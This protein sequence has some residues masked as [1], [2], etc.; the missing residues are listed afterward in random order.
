[1]RTK[2]LIAC[3]VFVTISL[4]A[5]GDTITNYVINFTTTSGSPTPAS[6]SFTYD[7]SNPLFS[8]FLVTWNG[9][10]FDLTALANAPGLGLIGCTGES[11]TPAYGF[12][13]LSQSLAGCAPTYTWAAM[14]L[15]FMPAANFSFN[16]LVG[17][18][19]ISPVFIPCSQCDTVNGGSPAPNL[20]GGQ[21]IASGT[22]SISPVPEPASII[23]T[24]TGLLGLLGAR[25]KLRPNRV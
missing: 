3:L 6:G 4:P 11:R 17:S 24:T 9:L 15:S 7:S 22:W 8:N 10:T 1:M 23:L 12:S 19:A 2:L 20:P 18:G 25:R 5:R 14:T 21:V 13:L 16:A